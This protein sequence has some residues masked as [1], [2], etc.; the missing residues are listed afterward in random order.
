[1]GPMKLNFDIRDIFRAPRLA[2]SGKKIMIMVVGI[3]AGYV[4]Y[5]VL[6]AISFVL[7]G[8]SLSDMWANYGLYPCLHSLTITPPWYA[9]VVYYFGITLFGIEILFA[10]TAVSRV[11][12]KQ[13]KGDE[14]FSSSDAFKYVKKHW[15]AVIMGPVTIA[16]IIAFFLTFSGIFALFGKIPY[17]GEFLFSIPYL[18]YFLGSLFTVYTL[19]VL[20]VSLHYT[21]AIV[22]A[23]EEDTMG[24]VFQSYSIT[25][26]Q[27]WRILLYNGVLVTI[28]CI[29]IFLFKWFMTASFSLINYV[30]SCDWFMGEKLNRMVSYAYE[31]VYPEF[32]ASLCNSV[33][34]ISSCVTNCCSSCLSY[35]PFNSGA[36]LSGTETVSAVILGLFL[37]VIIASV[38]AYGLSIISVG[39]TIMYVIFKKKSDDDNLLERKDEDEIDDDDDNDDFNLDDDSDNTDEPEED[40]T[41]DNSENQNDDSNSMDEDTSK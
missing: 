28:L 21:P 38:F 23:S 24:T 36:D 17:V 2:L 26:S 35:I 41:E 5:W 18:F 16:L 40:E 14:F 3:L 22:G 1:M 6:T 27:P 15:V 12:Y 31:N 32:I 8:Y 10:C 29:G 7:S 9:C 30:F 20:L 25:W 13:L 4:S 19:V 39:E 11:T 34:C 37:F 33:C